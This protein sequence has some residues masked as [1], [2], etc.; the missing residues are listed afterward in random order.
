MYLC[1]C[2]VFLYAYFAF[3]FLGVVWSKCYPLLFNPG[4]PISGNL[5][6]DFLGLLWESFTLTGFELHYELFFFSVSFRQI[7]NTCLV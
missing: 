6:F 3:L 1:V 2:A 7:V 5:V 4:K